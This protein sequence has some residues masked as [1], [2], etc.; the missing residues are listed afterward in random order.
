MKVISSIVEIEVGLVE[1]PRRSN[2]I[3]E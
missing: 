2:K 3:C 1:G